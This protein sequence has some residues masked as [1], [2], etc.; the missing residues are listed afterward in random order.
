MGVL[1]HAVLALLAAPGWVLAPSSVQAACAAGMLS[2]ASALASDWT[3]D[4]PGLC[5]KILVADLG[6][7]TPSNTNVRTIVRPPPGILPEVPAG[8]AVRKFY[9]GDTAGRLLRAQYNGDLFLAE[10]YAGRIRV[11]RPSGVCRLGSTE[12]F[13]DKLNLPFGIAFAPRGPG[14]QYLYVAEN[15]RIVRFPYK[16]GQLRANASP[17]VIASLPVGAGQLPGQGHWT[18]DIAFGPGAHTLYASIG[19]FS[20]SQ[21]SGEDETGRA[22]IIAMDPLGGNRRIVATGIRNPVSISVSPVNYALWTSTNERD[23]LG[24]GLVPDY[25]TAVTSGQFYGWPWFY[26]GGHVDPRHADDYPR[27]HPPIAT[28]KVL[29]Q[30]H[31]ASLGS[32]FYTQ[33]LFPAEYHGSLFV[34][35]HGSWNKKSPTGAKVVRLIFDGKGNAAPYYEDFMTGFTISDYE[36]WGRPVGVAVGKDGA[37]YVSEDANNTI[38]CVAPANEMP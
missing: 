5:R 16:P 37:L 28:P 14:A 15:Q 4:K 32:A 25:V 35:E 7:P 22:R 29:L 17:Q 23:G 33:T 12:I 20:N 21:S 11:L 31:S 19:S 24:D 13:A 8:F 26:M 38:W 36:V 30:P 9:Q 18:R 6:P 27:R 10:S 2:G 3:D 34:A 1:K